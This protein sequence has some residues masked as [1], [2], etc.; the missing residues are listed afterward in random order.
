M[1]DVSSRGSGDFKVGFVRFGAFEV[2]FVT[3]ELRKHGTRLRVPEQSLEILRALV[4]RPGELVTRESICGRLWP[5]GTFVGFEHGLNA[6]VRRLREVLGDGAKQPRYI[7]TLPR[8]GYRFIGDLE[9]C[10]VASPA[11]DLPDKDVAPPVVDG[12]HAG[13][14]Y[15]TRTG[16]G[17]AVALAAALVAVIAGVRFFS[18]RPVPPLSH[19]VPLT[20]LPGQEVMPVFSPDGSQLAFAWAEKGVEEGG[21]FDLFSKVP[22]SEKVLRLT[23]RPARW[24]SPVW[25]P[26]GR[27]IAFSRWT[28]DESGIYMVPALGGDERKLAATDLDYP[29]MM[30][31]AFSPDGRDIVFIGPGASLSML[32]LE[33][34]QRKPLPTEVRCL[35]A[36]YPAFSPDGRQIAFTCSSDYGSYGIFVV[37]RDGGRAERLTQV[38]GIPQGLVWTRD[39]GI[40]FSNDTG[41]NEGRLEALDP[42]TREVKHLAVSDDARFPAIS[43]DGRRLAFVRGGD[44]VNIWALGSRPGATPRPFIVSTR[45]QQD[46]RFSPDGRRV[47]FV[48]TRSGAHEVWLADAD[49]SN[50]IQATHFNAGI[51]GSASW[52]SD[53]RRFAFDSRVNGPVSIYLE[54]VQERIPHRLETD[55]SEIQLPTWSRDCRSL[56]V[57]AGAAKSAL[58]RIPIGG[59]KAT[60]LYKGVAINASESEGGTIFF[61]DAFENANIRRLDPGHNE[62]LPLPDMPRVRFGTAWQLTQS[63]I[64]FDDAASKNAALIS[65]HDFATRSTRRIAELQRQIVP[66]TPLSISP[67]DRSIIYSQVD[68]AESDIM[69]AEIAR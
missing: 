48:S 4:E 58:Y 20:S 42:S 61:A 46:A 43:P 51:S 28:E 16:L 68:D 62:T 44:K 26:D 33:S 24:I 15:R 55:L 40:V 11:V 5:D 47:V 35:M 12:R 29:P 37:S 45:I 6:A 27:S 7:E 9:A 57:V 22:G 60:L 69:I 30:G 23:H 17:I 14:R 50:P 38:M 49:G 56:Y 2:D 10:D 66:W 67:L 36:G 3:G 53:S 65:Y 41:I 64:Y 18:T 52:C 63:G 8:R 34:L 21:G 54:D 13:Q 19:V 31:I 59:G 25:S 39:N 32:A 1:S